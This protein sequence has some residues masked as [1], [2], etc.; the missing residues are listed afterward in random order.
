MQ[1]PGKPQVTGDGSCLTPK[2]HPSLRECLGAFI[3]Q[4]IEAK[5]AGLYMGHGD[6]SN[7]IDLRN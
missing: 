6:G 5:V 3:Q 2:K 1:C 4:V 7:G